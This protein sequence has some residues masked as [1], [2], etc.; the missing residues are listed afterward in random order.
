MQ[1]SAPSQRA[2]GTQ[3]NSKLFKTLEVDLASM[4]RGFLHTCSSAYFFPL[5]SAQITNPH[6][7]WSCGVAQRQNSAKSLCIALL[8]H[9]MTRAWILGEFHI[10]EPT[11]PHLHPSQWSNL[12]TDIGAASSWIAPS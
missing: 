7:I 9:W 1:L 4:E 2:Q 10:T 6:T 3:V 12:W 5:I 11:T 8:Y